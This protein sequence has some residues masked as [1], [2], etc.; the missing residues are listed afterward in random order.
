MGELQGK[1]TIDLI[2]FYVNFFK[3]GQKMQLEY[4]IKCRFFYREMTCHG[5]KSNE[6]KWNLIDGVQF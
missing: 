4:M 5:A 1:F 6:V 3:W 2:L